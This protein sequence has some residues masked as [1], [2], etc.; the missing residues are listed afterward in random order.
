[1]FQ[2]NFETNKNHFSCYESN[3]WTMFESKYHIT[4]QECYE[5]LKT[6]KKIRFWLYEVQFIIEI[7]V[8]I[9][10]AQFNHFTADFSEILIIHWLTWIR[11]FNFNVRHIFDKRHITTNE[12]F[13]RFY[14]FSNN[15]NKVHEKN[16]DDFIDDQLNCVRVCLIQINGN[17]D[18]QFLKNEYSEKF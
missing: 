16:I 18:E 17:D 15:I 12:L 8:N 6:L 13:R 4:K 5:L 11:L 7:D 14:E 10:I 2:I 3:L 9:L 1:M